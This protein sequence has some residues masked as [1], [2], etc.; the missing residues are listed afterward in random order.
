[1]PIKVFLVNDHNVMKNGL[2]K[3]KENKLDIIVVGET[4]NASDCFEK[5]FNSGPGIL[6][7]DFNNN[8]MGEISDLIHSLKENNI[9]RPLLKYDNDNRENTDNIK[10]NIVV[11]EE[12]K[13][14]ELTNREIEV[15]KLISKGLLNKEVADMLCISERT[16]KNHISSIFKKIE[17]TD[18]TQA[19]VF[20]IKNKLINV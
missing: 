18:R 9:C 10:E 8:D 11:S 7:V 4:D 16:V 2:K 12:N 6:I 15:L 20:A 14:S 3:L 13:L 1:M 5:I 19:A 17:V